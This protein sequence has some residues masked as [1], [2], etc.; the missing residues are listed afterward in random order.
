MSDYRILVGD[1]REMLRT[2]P[3]RSVQCVV[4]SPPLDAGAVQRLALFV[5]RIARGNV[6]VGEREGSDA[7]LSTGPMRQG[8]VADNFGP[9]LSPVRLQGTQTE[10]RFGD[11]TLNAEV[12]EQC[13]EDAFCAKI[14]GLVAEKRP[15]LSNMCLLAVIPP[16]QGGQAGLYTSMTTGRTIGLFSV[17]VNRNCPT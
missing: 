9:V 8:A 15:S 17:L 7:H 2:L 3:E 16:A 13:A 1:C 11:F 5:Q 6:F 4:T 10:H 12:G 14:G